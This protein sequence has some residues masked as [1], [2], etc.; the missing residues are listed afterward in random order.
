MQDIKLNALSESDVGLLYNEIGGRTKVNLGVN[1]NT[2]AYD[3]E[4]K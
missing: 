2:T 4:S 1:C 3:T